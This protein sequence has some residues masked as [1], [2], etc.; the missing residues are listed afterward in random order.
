MKI[1]REKFDEVVRAFVVS[2]VCPSMMHIRDGQLKAFSIGFALPEMLRVTHG[3]M[4][5]FGYEEED[6]SIDIDKIEEGLMSGFSVQDKVSPAFF[7]DKNIGFDIED[8]KKFINLL[9]EVSKSP[10]PIMGV[11]E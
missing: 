11:T 1:T 9:R 10:S 5:K 3:M 2:E 7:D 4:A 6:G 8:G